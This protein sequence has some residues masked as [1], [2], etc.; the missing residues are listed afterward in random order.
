LRGSIALSG[1]A[2]AIAAA[3][4]LFGL[5]VL[6]MNSRAQD[7]PHKGYGITKTG[8]R[9]VYPAGYE[10]SPLT[11]LYASWKDVDGTDRSRPHSGVDGGRLGDPILAPAAGVVLAVWEADWGWGKEGALLIR[12][13]RQ[14]LNL[15][16]GPPYYYSE[17]D[18]LRYD[19][20]RTMKVGQQIARGQTIGHV[21]RPG[22][23]SFY[24][25]EVHLEVY[26]VDDD[27][28]L[29]WSQNSRGAAR[30]TNED[31]QLIDPL[32]LMAL[33]VL[34]R[35]GSSV[36]IQPFV[37]GADYS[38]FRGFTYILPCTKR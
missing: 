20:I 3:A 7:V 9:P 16:D 5:A 13:S 8:L 10:C 27:D 14:D 37:S 28:S 35:D 11:S 26:E 33:Q 25:P 30:W 34:P 31:A 24:L 32:Y 2:V 36:S 22:G 29:E 6:P 1:L 38:A 19:E 15:T 21:S 18:H 17:F 23:K 4:S 12:H